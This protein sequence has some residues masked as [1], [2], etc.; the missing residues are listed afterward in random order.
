M[1]LTQ[2]VYVARCFLAKQAKIVIWLTLGWALAAGMTQAQTP[3]RVALIVGNAAYEAEKPLKN[4]INDA[5]AIA[6]VL[7]NDLGFTDVKVLTNVR[8]RELI[9]AVAKFGD[10]ARGADAAVFY[11]SGHG[12]Q[13]NKANFLLP[14]DARIE[15]AEHVKAEGLDADDVLAALE[16]AAP[17]VS[18]MVLDACRDNPFAARTKSTSKGLSRPRNPEEGTL[19][20]FATR[21]GDVALDGTGNNSP[22]AQALVQSLKQAGQVPIQK[23]FDNVTE[24]VRKS[25]EGKQRPTR[26]GDLRV[27]VYLINPTITINNNVPP[28]PQPA[29]DADEETY[30]A[31]IA[32]D[33]V[34]AFDAYASAFPKGRHI[35]AV[36]I[37]REAAR[38]REAP[39]VAVAPAPA[40]APPAAASSTAIRPQESTAAIAAR[41]SGYSKISNSG[42]LLPDGAVLGERPDDWACTKDNATGLIWE[43]KTTSGLRDQKHKYSWFDRNAK[44]GNAGQENGGSCHELG[45]CD[46]EKFVVDANATALCGAKN[47]RMPSID[48]LRGIVNAEYAKQK[49]TIDPTFFPNTPSSVVWSGSPHAYGSS[50]AW[51]VYFGDGN[52]Y[53]NVRSLA[54]SV[55]LVRGGQ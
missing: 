33:T 43:V 20:A 18:L 36:T 23:M 30:K 24:Q 42:K 3:R 38:K 2:I 6:N 51:V 44:D 40:I 11:F 55:R 52:A 54:S 28:A 48:E 37:R 39:A 46:T 9:D 34:A 10:A 31:A 21:D 47:W 50:N 26:Y 14:V 19:I 32:A 8:R 29:L 5:T 22:Y 16:A 49:A 4:P 25:S 7:R 45:R 35:A 15:R 13:Q 27:D 53:G 17:R 41:T 1:K 12:Q